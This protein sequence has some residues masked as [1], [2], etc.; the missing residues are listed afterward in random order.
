MLVVLAVV[1]TA[2]HPQLSGRMDSI[3]FVLI[4]A[5]AILLLVPLQRLKSFKAAGLEFSLDQPQV[6]GAISSLQLDRIQDEK[7]RSSLARLEDQLAA[8]R[9]SRVLWIDDRPHKILAERRLLRA[10]GVEVVPAVSSEGAEGILE[11]DNDFDLIITDVQRLG[12]SYKLND[13]IEIHEGVNFVVKLRKSHSDPVV[14]LI[15]IIFYAAY[16]L[17]RLIRFTRPAREFYPTPDIANSVADLAPKVVKLLAE[18]RSTP[19]AAGERKKATSA[20]D[21]EAELSD[22]KERVPE[23]MG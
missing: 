7:L 8:I 15:P 21:H 4:G 3:F 20:R 17:E 14:Q 10:L 11:V 23:D 16:P 13:G 2:W 12:E 5:A 22:W 9:G 18:A 6:Q 1:R 19:I